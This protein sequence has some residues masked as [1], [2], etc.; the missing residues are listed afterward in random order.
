VTAVSFASNKWS[1]L[2]PADGSQI[3]RVSLGRDGM[4][5]SDLDDEA[6]VDSVVSE[7]SHHLGAQLAPNEVRVTRWPSSFPQYRPH[8]GALVATIER[9]LP[10]TIVA[11]G[12]S[13]HG[14][15]VPACVG[16]GR[17]AAQSVLS[18]L[19]IDGHRPEPVPD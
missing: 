13:L 18:R 6:V 5:V 7:V 1:H 9:S 16:S 8:H 17:R 14:I 4:D 10:A 15:G 3:L 2:R 12:A 19:G 11:A